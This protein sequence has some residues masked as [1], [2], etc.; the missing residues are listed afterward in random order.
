MQIEQLMKSLT[1]YFDDIQEGLWFKNLHPLLE[2]ASLEAI[3]GSLKRNP[4][5]ADVLKYDRPD[6]ILTLNQTPILVIERTIEVPSG[7]NVGQRYGRL[8][9]ASEAGVPLVYFGP[10]AARKHGGA[11]EGPRYMNLRLFYALDVM[12][13]VNGSAITTINWP[14]DQNFEI[15]QDPS[16]DKRMKEYLEMFFDNLLKY[17]IAGINLAIRNSSFQAEQLAEREKFVETMI[18]NPEQYD[19]PPD[20]VQILNAERF[21]NELGISENKRIICDEVVLYQVGMTY[22]RSDPYT[23]MALLYK[24]L[25]IL[26]SERNRCLILKFPNITTDMWKKVAFGSRERKDVRIYRSVSDGILFA[27]GY[28]SKEEL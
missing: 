7:H 4:N 15:L 12:Q 28:L 14:V 17:G 16:K 3:T 5:L 21:F 8:A 2:S 13:K 27:D 22:V 26:G 11:T 20:S 10:Y 25:Y 6:I 9:A 1:I 24:Y 19:V 18:T 23:G